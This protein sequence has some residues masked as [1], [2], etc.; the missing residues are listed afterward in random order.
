MLLKIKLRERR[1]KE[2]ESVQEINNHHSITADSEHASFYA[3]ASW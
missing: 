2:G 3:N 1:E